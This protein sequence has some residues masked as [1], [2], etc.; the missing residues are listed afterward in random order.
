MP[1]KTEDMKFEIIMNKF[2]GWLFALLAI[3]SL[4][5]TISGAYH[6]AFT[7]IISSMVSIAMF[8]ENKKNENKK[9]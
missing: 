6:Q 1:I 2:F 9:R 7:V 8:N 3:T 4:A 5:A